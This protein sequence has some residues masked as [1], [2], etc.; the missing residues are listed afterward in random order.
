MSLAQQRVDNTFLLLQYSSPGN[1]RATVRDVLDAQK[2]LLRAQ[3]DAT[4]ALVDYNIALLEFHRDAGVLQ[5]KPDGMW[6]TAAAD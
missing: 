6:Q 1:R 4:D 2:D 3:N 5:I